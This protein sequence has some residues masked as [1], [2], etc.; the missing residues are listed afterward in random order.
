LRHFSEEQLAASLVQILGN[1]LVSDS[2][3]FSLVFS[4]KESCKLN[5][6]KTKSWPLSF[7]ASLEAFFACV[8]L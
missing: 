8:V 4:L 7:L 2:E 3:A 5:N 6:A 1:F